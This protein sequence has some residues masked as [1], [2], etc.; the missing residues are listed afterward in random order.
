MQH[1][2][3]GRGEHAWIVRDTVYGCRILRDGIA[4]GAFVPSASGTCYRG[5]D[6][7]GGMFDGTAKLREVRAYEDRCLEES[8]AARFAAANVF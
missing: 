4:A 7:D 6:A 2:R 3:A 1:E 8:E 5:S